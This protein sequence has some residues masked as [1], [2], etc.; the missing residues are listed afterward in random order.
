[1]S[2]ALKLDVRNKKYKRNCRDDRKKFAIFSIYLSEA[3]IMRY[4]FNKHL[5]TFLS[6]VR[7]HRE[8]K[9]IFIDANMDEINVYSGKY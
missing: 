3:L 5:P 8:K 6:S 2:S 7:V 4:I 1:M 9:Q